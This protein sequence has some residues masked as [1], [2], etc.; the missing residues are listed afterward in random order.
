MLRPPKIPCPFP[1]F[2]NENP[3]DV[4]LF[5]QDFN[6]LSE[7]PPFIPG[8]INTFCRVAVLISEV[9]TLG[10]KQRDNEDTGIGDQAVLRRRSEILAEVKAMSSSLP[11]ALHY[12]HN[13]TPETCF[14][15]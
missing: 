1:E 14:L 11:P 8:V 6:K 4:D 15:G 2:H 5:G 9:L 12:E 13:F 3:A 7:R 10:E